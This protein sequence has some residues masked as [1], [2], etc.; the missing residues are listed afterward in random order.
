MD[1]SCFVHVG[2]IL[3]VL[4]IFGCGSETAEG[5]E[6]GADP[7]ID[8]RRFGDPYQVVGNF[9]PA[10]PDLYPM[11]SSDTLTVRVTYTGGC[12]SHRLE[13]DSEIR[14][15]TGFVWIRHD[16]RD[17]DCEGLIQDEIAT[18]LSERVL[19]QPVVALLHPQEGPP[20]ILSR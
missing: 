15:D 8:Q 2:W 1:T 16:A 19:E 10:D 4:L 7:T 3:V 20:Q 6:P 18:T 5:L 12:E 14:N 13:V 17:D 9:S 11:L